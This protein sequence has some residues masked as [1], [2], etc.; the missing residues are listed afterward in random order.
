MNKLLKSCVTGMS[1]TILSSGIIVNAEG[2]NSNE[3]FVTKEQ[4]NQLKNQFKEEMLE[5]KQQ[6]Q[7]LRQQLSQVTST[8]QPQR[9]IHQQV[10]T[11]KDIADLKAEVKTLKAQNE[12]LD[13]GTTGFL[14]TGYAFAGYSDSDSSNSSFNAGFNPIFLWRLTDD[15]IFEGE[16]ELELE[17]ET[18]NVSLEFAQLSYLLNDFVTIGVGKFLNP[19]N[20]FIERLHPTW[21]NKL[22]DRPITM[23]G[24]NRIQ[25]S[26]QLGF[27]VRGGIP[28]GSMR[29]EYAF[30]VSNGPSMRDDG[31]LSFKD[32]SDS[33]NN[34][35]VGGRIGWLPF[36]GFEVGY[37]FE[38]AG[39][40]DLNSGTLDV[41]THV[42]DLNYL[43][44]SKYIFGSIDI[45]GQYANREIDRSSSP[46]LAFDNNSSGGY[47]QIAYR[48]SLS[49]LPLLTDFESV[50]RYD[51]IELPDTPDF[52][53]E[54]RWTVGLN[55][56]LAA[57]TMVKF[58]YQFDDKQGA[59]DDDALIFQV[60]SGF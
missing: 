52:N 60:T 22:P 44:T 3:Q 41:V 10:K 13:D 54:Q 33:N 5:L 20:Y 8:Q 7:F 30:Y 36:P 35:A 29:G 28:F 37:G 49:G 6:V 45:R 47:A 15:L 9:P 46:S 23:V 39:V 11:E 43:K 56:Y 18:T 1:L 59:P 26:S 40:D 55:Y 2:L 34:K 19:S 42:V 4:Y 21:I 38:I 16:L 57:S 17:D 48:P 25:A 24:A 50:I 27:Q 58:A 32:F 12:A 53:D 31:T 14:L 51:W